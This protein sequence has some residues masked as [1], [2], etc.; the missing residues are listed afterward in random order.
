M[1][2]VVVSD[3]ACL[4]ALN[5]IGQLGL[6]RSVY[7][8]VI[9]TP[10]VASEFHYPLPEWIEIQ[11]PVNISL[12]T[13]LEKM[14][15]AGEASAIALAVEIKDCYLILDDLRARKIA[16]GMGLLFT[17][18]LGVIAVAKQRGIIPLAR[19]LLEK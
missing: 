11:P 19:P 16:A 14:I 1:E 18:T 9:I 2:R 13:S 5:K 7:G 15:D 6:L 17:G 10:T 4:I 8:Q 3:T 12:Q